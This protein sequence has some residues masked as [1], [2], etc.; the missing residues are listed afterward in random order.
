M[1]RKDDN[2]RVIT[3]AW[4]C[5]LVSGCIRLWVYAVIGF[6]KVNGPWIKAHLVGQ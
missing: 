5:L 4:V 1:K 6:W 2:D 3:F